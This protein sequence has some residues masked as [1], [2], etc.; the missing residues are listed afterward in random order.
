MALINCPCSRKLPPA[1][2]PKSYSIKLS[3][4]QR[5]AGAGLLENKSFSGRKRVFREEKESL[6]PLTFII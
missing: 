2:T 6:K 3:G 5:K 4:S 1:H